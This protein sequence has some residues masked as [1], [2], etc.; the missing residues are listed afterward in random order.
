MNEDR[1]IT[2]AHVDPIE[3]K[4]EIDRVYG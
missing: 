1:K 2:E 4:E 3:W